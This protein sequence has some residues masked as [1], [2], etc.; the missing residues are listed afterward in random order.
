[1]KRKGK[2]CM[3][4]GTDRFYKSS[5]SGGASCVGVAFSV[6]RVKVINTNTRGPVAEF[7]FPEWAA[8]VEGVKGGEF[9]LPHE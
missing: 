8:F 9:E 6:D 3:Q 1:M 5:S 4:I 7:T 2:F